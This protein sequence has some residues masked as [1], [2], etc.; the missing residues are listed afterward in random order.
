MGDSGLGKSSG[1]VNCRVRNE[2]ELDEIE[3]LIIEELKRT[4]NLIYDSQLVEIHWWRNKHWTRKFK[5]VFISLAVDKYCCHESSKKGEFL[6]DISWIR[7]ENSAVR[8]PFEL[9]LSCEIEWNS[10]DAALIDFRK[11]TVS[12][13]PYLVMIFDKEWHNKSSNRYDEKLKEMMNIIPAGTKQKYLLIGIK[14]IND[15]SNSKKLEY[16]ALESV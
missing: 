15:K 16:E 5:E 11:L 1:L 3:R 14:S 13:A 4:T 8:D 6:W 12:R 10:H 2:S 9:V 7:P